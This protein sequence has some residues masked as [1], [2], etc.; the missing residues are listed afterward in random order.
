MKLERSRRRRLV[1]IILPILIVVAAFSFLW[2]KK[3]SV[4]RELVRFVESTLS[5]ETD[6]KIHLGKVSGH[7]L[8]WASFK[9]VRVEAPW[10]PESRR[11]IFLAREI[12]FRYR[13]LDFIS[14][15]FDSKVV[16][17]I[18]KP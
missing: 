5:R 9:D 13:F 7:I 4:A 6:L 10:L 16:V 12:Q 8:G 14:K 15:K 17:I 11:T 18:D 2:V 3:D 1:R